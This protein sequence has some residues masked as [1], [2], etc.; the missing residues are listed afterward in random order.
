MTETAVKPEETN[1]EAANETPAPDPAVIFKDDPVSLA[2]FNKT[3]PTI[4]EYNELVTSL[5]KASGNL[6]DVISSVV[7]GNDADIV[8]LRDKRDKAKAAFDK[9]EE[10]LNA[11]AETKAQA[12]L[13]EKRDDAKIA[14]DTEKSKVLLSKINSVRNYIKSEVGEEAL[15][16]FPSLVSKSG[17]SGGGTGKGSGG[18]KLRGFTVTVNGKRAEMKNNNGEV[19][20]S[21]AAASKDAGV[22]TDV[23]QQGYYDAVGTNDAEQFPVGKTV[24][25]VVKNGEGNEVKITATKNPPKAATK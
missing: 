2:L 18:R 3:V 17:S 20:S 24:E 11:S 16:L 6:A 21:F 4:T 8:S 25:Y 5:K 13:A 10:A 22:S 12:I 9:A 7:E 15:A 23:L 19:V 1:S 14:A